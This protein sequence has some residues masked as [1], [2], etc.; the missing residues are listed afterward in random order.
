MTDK[1]IPLDIFN[2]FM[3]NY[4]NLMVTH[5]LMDSQINE[6]KQAKNMNIFDIEE[7]MRLEKLVDVFLECYVLLNLTLSSIQKTSLFKEVYVQFYLSKG[8]KEKHLRKFLKL[9]KIKITV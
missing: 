7:T 8:Q 5:E 9:S 4:E 2:T 6:I 1:V 3:A